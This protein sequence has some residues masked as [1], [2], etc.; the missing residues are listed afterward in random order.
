MD[1]VLAVLAAEVVFL[2]ITRRGARKPTIGALLPNLAAGLF[3][4]L[5]LRSAVTGDG[6]LPIAAFLGAAGVAHL[7]DLR[8]RMH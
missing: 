8:R 6:V 3:L 1:F 5:A 7:L 2:A 4:V